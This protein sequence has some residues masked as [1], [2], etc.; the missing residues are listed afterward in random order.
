MKI[1]MKQDKLAT[2]N[3]AGSETLVYKQDS[4]LDM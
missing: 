4:E 3:E 1:K 2:A